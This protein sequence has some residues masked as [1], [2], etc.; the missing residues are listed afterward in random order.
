MKG[1]NPRDKGVIGKTGHS[2]DIN[3]MLL[4][5]VFAGHPELE[6]L[7]HAFLSAHDIIVVNTTALSFKEFASD[8]WKTLYFE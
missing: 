8:Y 1:G 5:H 6:D 2:C 4:T 3:S 7:L